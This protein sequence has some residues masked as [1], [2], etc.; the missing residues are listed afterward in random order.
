MTVEDERF[1]EDEIIL[2]RNYILQGLEY[3]HGLNIVHLDIKV[4][5]LLSFSEI[6]III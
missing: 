4:T 1:S 5:S 2:P 6:L 3:L